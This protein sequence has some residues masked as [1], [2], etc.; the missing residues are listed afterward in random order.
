MFKLIEQNELSTEAIPEVL[1]HLA[2]NPSSSISETLESTGLGIMSGAE[3]EEIIRKIVQDREDIIREQGER[4]LGG[5]M[6]VVMKELGGK[7]D[8]KTVKQILTDE[9]NKLLNT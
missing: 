3:V 2:N 6:G 5:L 4:S 7:V 8:G 1:T 9:I